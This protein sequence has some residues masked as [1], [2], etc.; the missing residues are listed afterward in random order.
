MNSPGKRLRP[1]LPPEFY[2]PEPA[3]VLLYF[4]YSLVLYVGCGYA[5]YACAMSGWPLSLKIP[6]VVVCAFLA[7]NGL[8]VLGWLAHEGIHLSMVKHKELNLVLGCFAGS[9]LFFPTVGLGIAHW[10]HHRFT[11]RAEDPDTAVQSRCQTFWRR[12]L[13]GRLIAN[14]SYFRNAIKVLLRKPLHSGYRLPFSDKALA[15][16][17]ALNFGFMLLWAA[18]YAAIAMR[19]EA[20]FLLGFVL[21]YLL[22]IPIT[23]LRPYIEHAGTGTGEFQD[24]R[25][26]TSWFY[27]ILLFGN[28]YHLEHHLY[29]S[30]PG[31]KLPKVHRKLA[32]EGYFERLQ[33]PVVGGVIAP[34]RFTSGKYQ[35]PGVGHSLQP[36]RSAQNT[37]EETA[38]A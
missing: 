22:M 24:A 4:T 38:G 30:V 11:N 15:R 33:A 8:H 16:C 20:Y 35:Y 9:L 12:L 31:Y 28:N 13:F 21:P 7:S 26:Y 32:A 19:N 37:T 1:P 36:D 27:T 2:R 29:P 3:W 6:T 18:L 14:R 17:S 23:G 5:C 10:P 34:L 25:S